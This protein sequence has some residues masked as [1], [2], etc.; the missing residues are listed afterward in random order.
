MSIEE[1]LD[2]IASRHM[3]ISLDGPDMTMISPE[4]RWTLRIYANSRDA[5]G[6]PIDCKMFHGVSPN[7]VLT[8]ALDWR[9]EE[10]P[11]P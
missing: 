2:D 3:N 10:T 9:P 5:Y 8:Q 11:T 6:T 7:D 1:L 4:Y